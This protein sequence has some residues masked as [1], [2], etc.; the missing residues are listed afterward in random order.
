MPTSTGVAKLA[1]PSVDFASRI[2]LKFSLPL[3]FVLKF[4][5]ATYNAPSG[6]TNGSENWFSLHEPLKVG[7]PKVWSHS[8]GL[9]PLTSTGAL[10]VSP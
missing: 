9:F 4:A 10:K 2:R 8:V 3:T 6:P 5:K 7:R 1:P